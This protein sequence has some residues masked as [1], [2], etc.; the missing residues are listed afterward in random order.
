[1]NASLLVL[2]TPKIRYHSKGRG[3]KELHSPSTL[4]LSLPRLSTPTACQQ[5]SNPY[6][7]PGGQIRNPSHSQAEIHTEETW[8]ANSSNIATGYGHTLQQCLAGC[9]TWSLSNQWET[10]WLHNPSK[11]C[12][13]SNLKEDTYVFTGRC[14]C[15]FPV[16]YAL[17]VSLKHP[18]MYMNARTYGRQGFTGL[19]HS[20]Q[21]SNCVLHNQVSTSI[22]AYRYNILPLPPPQ[23]RKNNNGIVWDWDKWFSRFKAYDWKLQ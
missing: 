11:Q 3:R 4:S 14:V 22:E 15:C 20:N 12:Y 16:Y 1:M 2:A 5:A 19:P 18:R 23:M 7:Q 13:H 17:S 10:T 6:G 21:Y 8:T 9:L